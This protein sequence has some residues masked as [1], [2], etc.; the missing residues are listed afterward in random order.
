MTRVENYEI[1]LSP[2]GRALWTFELDDASV[3]LAPR[4]DA[5]RFAFD[6]DR[7]ELRADFDSPAGDGERA[8]CV[9]A[10]LSPEA[11]A[12]ARSASSFFL[13]P[14]REGRMLA[15]L[16]LPALSALSAAPPARRPGGPR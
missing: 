5:P 11:Q 9:F 1:T 2:D 7:G 12:V 10:P 8:S 14:M 6:A 16:G 3:S 15:A 13:C 4:G